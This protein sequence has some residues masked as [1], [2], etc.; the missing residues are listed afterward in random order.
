[1][2]SY[3]G[4]GRLGVDE[5]DVCFKFRQRVARQNQQNALHGAPPG[6]RSTSAIDRDRLLC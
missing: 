3:T 5:R 6:A 1:M 4:I 2:E